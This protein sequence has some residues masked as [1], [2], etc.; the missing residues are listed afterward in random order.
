MK[1]GK[2]SSGD[3]PGGEKT[4]DPYGNGQKKGWFYDHVP[5]IPGKRSQLFQG[6][7]VEQGEKKLAGKHSPQK[8]GHSVSGDTKKDKAQPQEHGG[9]ILQ[10]RSR[11][12]SKAV[13]DASGGGGKVEKRAEPCQDHDKIPGVSIV[14]YRTSQIRA[15]Q[16]KN[17]DA[18]NAHVQAVADGS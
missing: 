3:L 11:I 8:G 12:F 17:A 6:I 14:E 2:N 5:G 4:G 9:R 10:K 13:E 18:Q 16:G 15:V 7:Q 1:P